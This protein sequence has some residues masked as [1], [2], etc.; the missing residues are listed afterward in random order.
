MPCGLLYNLI[1]VPGAIGVADGSLTYGPVAS[2]N[3]SLILTAPVP[4]EDSSRFV[5]PVVVLHLQFLFYLD[6]S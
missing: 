2:S 6:K 3:T 1:P 5:L 4:G